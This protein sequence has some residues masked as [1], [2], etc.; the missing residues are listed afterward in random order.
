[1]KLGRP[2]I[3]RLRS[4]MAFALVLWCAGTGCLIASYAHGVAMG[5]TREASADAVSLKVT[6]ASKGGHACCKARHR[7]LRGAPSELT[8]EKL[9]A[10][11]TT[12]EESSPVANSCCPLTSGSFVIGSRVQTND[13]DSPALEQTRLPESGDTIVFNSN[14]A[15]PLRLPHHRY[16]Y[17]TCCAFLI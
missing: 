2:L 17:L 11:F 5:V 15:V 13:D 12:P 14:R 1:M 6:E 10:T 4:T 3:S 9:S 8:A 16:D 7:A